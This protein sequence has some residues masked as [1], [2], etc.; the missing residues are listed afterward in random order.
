MMRRW[1]AVGAAMLSLSLWVTWLLLE[2]LVRAPS[3]DPLPQVVPVKIASI[4]P[5]PAP[6]R[7]TTTADWMKVP[8]VVFPTMLVSD[9]ALWR[10]MHFDDWDTVPP[11]FRR[12]GLSAIVAAHGHLLRAPRDWD[13]M[14][15]TDWDMIPQPVRAVAYMNMVRYWSGYYQV[16]AR[17]SLARGATTNTLNAIVMAESWFEHR[18]LSTSRSGNRDLGLGQASDYARETMGRLFSRGRIDFAPEADADY[19]N[20]WVASRM[21]A[22]WFDLMLDEQRGDLDAAVRAYHAGSQQSDSKAAGEYLSNVVQKRRRFMRD[23]TGTPSWQLLMSL[24]ESPSD[25]LPVRPPP[26]TAARERTKVPQ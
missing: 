8:V 12:E 19:F 15:A 21:T 17:H 13:G 24:S 26:S 14:S 10:R 11:R 1:M 6:I 9:P 22:I 23:R 18:A 16:G 4:F 2:W 25:A 5:T 3:P 20:P 7:I